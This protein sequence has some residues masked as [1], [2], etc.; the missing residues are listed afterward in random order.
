MQFPSAL[1]RQ[2]AHLTHDLTQPDADPQAVINALVD[3][4]TTAIPSFLGLTVSW[5]TLAGPV[6]LTTLDSAAADAAGTS[7]LLP[8]DLLAGTDPGSSVAFYAANPGAFVDLAA[9][10]RFAYQLD[11]DIALDHHLDGGVFDGQPSDPGLE[12]LS[13]I[14][15]ALGVLIDRGHAPGEAETELHRRA[16]QGAHTL[17]QAAVL[18]LS[19]LLTPGR[20]L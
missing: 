7:L 5:P 8:L 20:R 11:G 6:T 10:T 14:N 1:K 9:D 3:D 12:D 16:T 13:Q 15:Q 4:L 2:L 17:H 18:V 19:T